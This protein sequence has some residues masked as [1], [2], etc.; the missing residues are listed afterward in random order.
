MVPIFEGKKLKGIE[1]IHLSMAGQKCQFLEEPKKTIF[2]SSG[3]ARCKIL[4]TTIPEV[5]LARYCKGDFFSCE[6]FRESM[7]KTEEG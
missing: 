6:V 2:G 1:Y 7:R 5:R 4:G 3:Q